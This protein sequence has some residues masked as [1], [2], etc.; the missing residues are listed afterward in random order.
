MLGIETD[1]YEDV[2]V[3][4]KHRLLFHCYCVGCA[5]MN[6]L[7]VQENVLDV[8]TFNRMAFGTA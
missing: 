2:W 3:E 7:I 6:R 5:C 1:T 4:A 8:G